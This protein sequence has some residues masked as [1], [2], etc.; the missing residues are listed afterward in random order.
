MKNFDKY[1]YYKLRK[2][3]L[4]LVFLGALNSGTRLF[5][6]DLVRMFGLFIKNNTGYNLSNVINA[7]ITIAAIYILI[8]DKNIWTPFLGDVILPCSLINKE[9]PKNYNIIKV[10]QTTPNTKIMYWASLE[11]KHGQQ[12]WNAYGDYSNSGVVYSDEHGKA[13]LK[14]REPSEYIIP[15]GDKLSKH[16]HYRECPSKDKAESMLSPLKTIYL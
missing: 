16:L 2:L 12:V 7:I 4:N 11:N 13:V 9:P 14:L 10:I 5:N 15:T 8:V 6:I 1:Y 3:C